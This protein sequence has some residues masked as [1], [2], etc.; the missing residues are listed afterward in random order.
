MAAAGSSRAAGRRR[1]DRLLGGRIDC[2]LGPV[3]RKGS[4]KA[5]EPIDVVDRR[6]EQMMLRASRQRHEPLAFIQEREVFG[7]LADVARFTA[8][9]LDAFNSLI[10][11]GALAAVAALAA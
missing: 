4:T 8:S 11:H 3:M 1:P 6:R 10:E 5:G 9:Y 7:E 2:K